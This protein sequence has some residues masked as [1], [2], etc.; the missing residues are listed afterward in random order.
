MWK[1]TKQSKIV[2]INWFLN[3][4]NKKFGVFFPKKD[5]KGVPERSIIHYLS[6]LAVN[7][8]KEQLSMTYWLQKCNL[9]ILPELTEMYTEL[10]LKFTVESQ[11]FWLQ[12]Y[13]SIFFISDL[14]VP[15]PA[16]GHWQKASF[17]HLMLI[18]LSCF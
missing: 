2:K 18:T 4:E 9:F 7:I 3:V 6:A 16:S 13:S 10:R 8:F 5:K 1:F 17:P 15:R 11:S 12:K 14:A